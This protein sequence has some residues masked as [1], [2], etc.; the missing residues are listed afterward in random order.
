MRREPAQLYNHAAP[1]YRRWS[2]AEVYSVSPVSSE[3]C[4]EVKM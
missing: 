4:G 3:K 2:L 1:R